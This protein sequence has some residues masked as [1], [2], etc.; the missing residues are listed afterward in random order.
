[1]WPHTEEWAGAGAGARGRG[2]VRGRGWGRG[3][4]RGGDGGGVRRGGGGGGSKVQGKDAVPEPRAEAEGAQ[5][6]SRPSPG[7]QMHA[8]Y[9]KTCLKGST[10]LDSNIQEVCVVYTSNVCLCVCARACAL[11]QGHPL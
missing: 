4:G 7:A 2:R 1:M 6:L 3:R 10:I 5:L 8:Y 9:L 11:A